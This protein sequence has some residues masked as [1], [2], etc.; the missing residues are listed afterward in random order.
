MPAP[1]VFGLSPFSG[2]FNAT[3]DE[4]MLLSPSSWP[5]YS[6]SG[7]LPQDLLPQ[8]L[9]GTWSPPT[10]ASLISTMESPDSSLNSSRTRIR[11]ETL[12]IATANT[13]VPLEA[14]S[15]SME[16]DNGYLLNEFLQGFFPPILA[17]VE[18]GPKWSTTRSFFASMCSESSMVRLAV[19]AFSAFQLSTTR[20]GTPADYKPL[21][22]SASREIYAQ[23]HTGNGN[24]ITQT[25]LK[26]LLA[27]LF[28]LTY[29]D[30]SRGLKIPSIIR[31][32]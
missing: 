11:E 31:Y 19:M 8:S 28:L 9:G 16:N 17:P 32:G 26:H 10:L 6:T 3:W 15:V 30:V 20:S 12:A 1:G 22:D 7:P 13:S 23:L 27:A 2:G 24:L 29:A 5:D 21:Y 14:S 18:I 4:A 25:E